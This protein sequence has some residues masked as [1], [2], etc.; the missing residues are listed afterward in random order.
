M[1]QDRRTVLLSRLENRLDAAGETASRMSVLCALTVEHLAV[2]GAGATVLASLADGDGQ[3]PSRGLVHATNEISTGLEDL[4]LTVGEGPCLDAFVT[5]GPVLIAD[6]ADNH[7]RWPGFTPGA[8]A[9]GAA[10]VFSFPLHIGAARLGSLDLYHDRPGKLSDIQISD[11]LILADLATHAVVTEL[12]GHASGD[13]GWLA[14]PH[15]E[16]HQATGMIQAQLNTTT[17][18]ALLRLRAHAYTYS[19]PLLDV[20]RRITDRRLRFTDES[21]DD[22]QGTPA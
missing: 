1:S 17:E 5:G 13:A 14:D 12:E 8:L 4:Q 11:A 15:A 16:I 18:N 19:L 20:A 10:S 21:D 22:Q 9:W 2:S 3:D 6:L 7:T